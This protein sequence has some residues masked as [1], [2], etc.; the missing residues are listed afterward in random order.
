MTRNLLKEIGQGQ[1][2]TDIP[3]SALGRRL[4]M[5]PEQPVLPPIEPQKQQV[6][7][8]SRR[9]AEPSAIGEGIADAA[10]YAGKQVVGAGEAAMSLASGMMLYVPSKIA[11]AV[12]SALGQDPRMVEEWF[13]TEFLPAYQPYTKAGQQAVVPIQKLFEWG[14]M[15]AHKVGEIVEKHTGSRDAG[16]AAEMAAEFATF[17]AVGGAKKIV[18]PKAKPFKTAKGQAEALRK[19]KLQARIKELDK[20]LGILATQEKLAGIGKGKVAGAI[21]KKIEPKAKIPIPLFKKPHPKAIPIFK[22]KVPKAKGPIIIEPGPSK[23]EKPR[24]PERELLYPTKQREYGEKLKGLREETPRNL[25]KEIKEKLPTATTDKAIPKRA[26]ADKAELIEKEGEGAAV[27]KTIEPFVEPKMSKEIKVIYDEAMSEIPEHIRKDIA[28]ENIIVSKFP[29]EYKGE[30]GRTIITGKLREPDRHQ[31]VLELGEKN[32]KETLKHELLHTYVLKHPELVKEGI[33]GHEKAVDLLSK[34]LKKAKPIPPKQAK[35][36]E[37]W[38]MGKEEYIGEKPS[39]ITSK[40]QHEELKRKEKEIKKRFKGVKR[41]SFMNRTTPN[42]ARGQE[43]D[44]ALSQIEVD[45]KNIRPRWQSIEKGSEWEGKSQDHKI[46]VKRALSEN[47]PVPDAVLK[48]Y[49]ELKPKQPVKPKKVEPRGA[50]EAE[51]PVKAKPEGKVGGKPQPVK[52]SKPKEK[53]EPKDV[54]LES[55]GF[56]AIYES[57][58]QR[59]IQNRKAKG[60][61]LPKSDIRIYNEGKIVKQRKWKRKAS[62]GKMKPMEAPPIYEAELKALKNMPELRDK[63]LGGW[64]ENPIR[65]FEELGYDIKEMIYRPIKQAE[66]TIV[67]ERKELHRK[68]KLLKK[69][70]SWKSRKKIGAYAIGRQKRGVAILKALRIDPKIKLTPQEMQVYN[71]LR[72]QF[73][74]FYKRLNQARRL[75]GKEPFKKV[76]NYFTF[77]RDLSIMEKLGF[78]PI[79]T[80]KNYMDAQFVHLKTTP[81]RFAKPRVKEGAMPVELDAFSIFESYAEPAIKHIHLSPHIS[82][83]REML[84][85]FGAKKDLYAV[86]KEGRQKAVKVF[87][88]KE[89]A[90]AFI[91][92]MKIENASIDIRVGKGMRI[93]ESRFELGEIKPRANKF[94]KEWLDFVAGQKPHTNLPNLIEKGLTKLNKNLT[95]AILSGS[96]RSA[97]I[98]PTAILNTMVE[99]GPIY[100]WKGIQSLIDPKMRNEAY[101]KSD[102]VARQYDVAATD[103]MTQIRKSKLGGIQQVVGTKGLKGLSILDM[104]TAKAT[105]QGAYQKAIEKMNF[106]ERRAINY[107]NDVVTRTQASAAA[108]DVAPIQRT[109]FGKAISLFQTFVINQWGFITK[110]VM[111]IKNAK[112]T[113]KETFK[114]VTSFIAGATLIN[115]FYEDVIG[116]FSPYPTPIREFKEALERGEDI[117]SASIEAAKELVEMVPIIGGGLRY[118]KGML[119]ASVEVVQDISKGKKPIETI[120]KIAGVPGTAQAAKMIKAKKRGETTYGQFLGVYTPKHKRKKKGSSKLKGLSGGLKGGLKGLQ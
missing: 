89:A 95:F 8:L 60:I 53:V 111:G 7:P 15:P 3:Q 80:K 9:A 16:Y 99:I 108:S 32:I 70:V 105:W 118:G 56:Q 73:E 119:G 43:L 10:M 63:P 13:Q 23:I 14:L 64:L 50:E 72:G 48:E 25:V 93:K 97:I 42:I 11:G 78:N 82:K 68:L 120:S 113:N 86:M 36:K 51:K 20:P 52:L 61:N 115:I 67:V 96:I 102:L 76:E 69:G 35:G 40:E 75:S 45:R 98:Q 1:V 19:E 54:T 58:T 104:E 112:M 38:E 84:G 85:V 37:A 27:G 22:G 18:T 65:T 29:P 81:F 92:E 110:D 57:V 90:S 109:A 55:G 87:T 83:G 46:L 66:K 39:Q 49:P 74:S 100:T 47:K 44:K 17:G 31:I 114:K 6:I 26:V 117:P 33:F 62:D 28:V 88:T 59:I 24:F 77:F 101:T 5:E 2:D 30:G 12:G 71:I 21:G 41:I 4:L 34:E 116:V 94:L 79:L 91:T 106:T 107:A 103:A